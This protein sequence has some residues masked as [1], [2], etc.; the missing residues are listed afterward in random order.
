VTL[1]LVKFV[2]LSALVA[3]SASCGDVSRTGRSPVQIVVQGLTAASGAEPGEMGGTLQSDVVVLVT[4]EPCS[5]ENPCPTIVNDI[6]EVEMALIL[7]NPGASANPAG[8]SELNAVTIN[9]YRVE[10]RRADGRNVQGVDVPFSFDS[11]VTFTIPAGGQATAG[12]Q[13]VRHTA[14][15][16]APLKALR[17]NGQI[18]STIAT[19]TFYGQDQAGN[20]ISAAGNIGIDFGDFADPQ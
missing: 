13:I 7:K 14:K 9:R 6:G 16:E 2:A 19:V 4:D 15:Q 18:I 11:S 17:F 12:F 5:K 10:Y 8:P 1:K 20:D 3:L